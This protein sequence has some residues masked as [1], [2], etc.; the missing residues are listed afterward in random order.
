MLRQKMPPGRYGKMSLKS[1]SLLPLRYRAGLK[2]VVKIEQ[3]AI[4]GYRHRQNN[5]MIRCC[6]AAQSWQLQ[7]DLHSECGA[8][9]ATVA[10]D[11]DCGLHRFSCMSKGSGLVVS[12][13]LST[14][15][16]TELQELNWTTSSRPKMHSS[17]VDAHARISSV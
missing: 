1:S 9:L 17:T 2:E 10:V 6:N 15:S 11:S 8:K 14:H 3:N 7:H 5:L 12:N 16:S 13:L 4:V